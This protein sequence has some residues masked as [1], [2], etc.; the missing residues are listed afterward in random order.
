MYATTPN[1]Q[2]IKIIGN[3]CI[4]TVVMSFSQSQK[5]KKRMEKM[6]Q[7]NTKYFIHIIFPLKCSPYRPYVM[8]VMRFLGHFQL[9]HV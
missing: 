1:G 4:Y 3:K 9:T 7:I 8:F 6:L 5:N 2:V